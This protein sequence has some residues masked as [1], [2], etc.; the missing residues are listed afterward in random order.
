M[1]KK[2]IT[3]LLAICMILPCAF[4]FSSCCSEHSWSFNGIPTVSESGRLRCSECGKEIELPALNESDY[5]ADTTNP[6]H[7]IFTYTTADNQTFQFLETNFS[8]CY[9]DGGSKLM[10]DGYYGNSTHVVIP[11]VYGGQHYGVDTEISS[12]SSGCFKNNTTVTSITSP[13]T[14][15]SYVF[16]DCINLEKIYY[17]GTNEQWGSMDNALSFNREVYCYSETKPTGL[18]YLN[19]NKTWHYDD[20]NNETIW[21]LNFTNNVENKSFTY[22]HSEVA[23]SDAY[24]A[25]LKE[26]ETQNMLGDLFDND[27]Q[28]IEMVTSSATKAE[29]ETKFAAWYG[30]TMGTQAVVSFAEDKMTV[31]LSGNSGQTDYIEV[32]GEIYDVAKKEKVFAFDAT[33]NSIYEERADEYSTIRHIYSIVE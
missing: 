28:Q 3:L 17:C 20:N 4:V 22:S 13:I 9:Y 8:F 32:D 30:T 27:Q 11:S 6:D 19:N 12:I 24:W 10:I 5:K 21:E 18:D 2:F 25:M 29:Y 16:P 23:F 1:K 31:T 33:N 7:K 15:P 26:A 14:L